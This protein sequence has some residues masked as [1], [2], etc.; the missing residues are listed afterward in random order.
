MED[1]P[2]RPVF[3]V[4]ARRT[5]VGPAR[6][7][8][9]LVAKG[10]REEEPD[11]SLYSSPVCPGPLP[12]R[13]L[14]LTGLCQARDQPGPDLGLQTDNVFVILYII[15]SMKQAANRYSVQ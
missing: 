12:A 4:R 2:A 6:P 15:G 14:T 10:S 1:L 13:V 3:A 5:A 9:L 11:S 8:A 7:P